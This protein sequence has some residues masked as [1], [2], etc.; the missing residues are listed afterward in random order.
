MQG[1]SLVSDYEGIKL[2]D[3]SVLKKYAQDENSQQ[4]LGI[5][6]EEVAPK[7]DTLGIGED[8]SKIK[9][10]ELSASIDAYI[11]ESQRSKKE[12]LKKEIDQLKWGLIEATLAEKNEEVKLKKVAELR[13]KNMRPFFL[14]ELE[15]ADVFLEKGGFDVVIGNPPYVGEKGNKEM[16]QQI[17]ESSLGQRFGIG[18]MDLFYYFFHLGLD[19]LKNHGFLTF[20]TTNYFPT[21]DGAINLRADLYKRSNIVRLINFGEITVFD[22]ARGQHNLITMIQRDEAPLEDYET[23]QIKALKKESVGSDAISNLL[24]GKGELVSQNKVKKSSV[25]SSVDENFYIRF[26]SND[27]EDSLINKLANNETLGK[28]ARTKEG[29]HTGDDSAFVFPITFKDKSPNFVQWHKGSEINHYIAPS[30][31]NEVLLY[32]DG[33]TDISEND[34][35]LLLPHYDKLNAR[36][37]IKNGTYEWWRLKRPRTKDLFLGKKIINPYRSKENRFALVEEPWFA[38]ADVFITKI[39]DDSIKYEFLL[40][41]LNSKVIYYWLYHRGKRKGHMLEMKTTPIQEIPI[42]TPKDSEMSEIE[43]LVREVI[44]LKSTDSEASTKALET[45]INELVMELYGLNDDEKKIIR[46]S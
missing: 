19:L 13:R 1:N 11:S 8:D 32:L 3:P 2:F 31:T 38:S 4:S 33:K 37:E 21:A 12:T 42:P 16:F 29:L 41:L 36:S 14:W 9:L 18:K 25:F 44:E 10:K 24:Y 40:G 28:V 23:E 6:E 22:S 39:T 46:N 5:G 27:K 17:R 34:K 43:Q 45:E 15:F 30:K 20:I 7:Q 35:N 26:V